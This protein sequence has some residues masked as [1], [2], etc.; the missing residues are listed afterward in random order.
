MSKD[1]V[2][3]D[4]IIDVSE[5]LNTDSVE[6]T[7]DP[8]FKTLIDPLTSAEYEQLEK[9]ILTEGVSEPLKVWK[10]ED[11]L[12]LIDGHNRYDIATKNTLPFNIIKMNFQSRQDAIIWNA[13][14]Q[15]GRRNLT[16]KQKKNLVGKRI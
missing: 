14:N 6:I 4:E 3:S 16:S 10:N 15:L 7:I 9:N 13:N 8:E 5:L 1:D 12:L 2:L 11:K